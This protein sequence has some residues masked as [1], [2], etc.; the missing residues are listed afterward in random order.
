[1]CRVRSSQQAWSLEGP[2][3]AVLQMCP[4]VSH[5]P[6]RGW[7]EGKWRCPWWGQATRGTQE[8]A[9]EEGSAGSLPLLQGPAV[10]NEVSP[11]KFLI[12]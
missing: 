3:G 2:L 12:K 11:I 5:C 7:P 8:P 6:L 1:M 10:G 4:A 9:Q